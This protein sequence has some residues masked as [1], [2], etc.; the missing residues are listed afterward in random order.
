[1][2]AFCRPMKAMKKPM[3]APMA[4]FREAG[5]LFTM[6]SR[7]LK[8]VSS[9]KMTPSQKIAVSAHRQEYPMPTHTV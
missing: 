4:F 5:M 6:A 2:P 1:M 8:K 9:R 3:P 7:M